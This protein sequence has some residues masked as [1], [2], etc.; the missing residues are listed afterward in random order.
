MESV[1]QRVQRRAGVNDSQGFIVEV[2]YELHVV[3]KQLEYIKVA[4][5]VFHCWAKV[6]LC[7]IFFFLF[8]FGGL[9]KGKHTVYLYYLYWTN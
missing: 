1:I 9:E 7:T 6:E 2:T 4:T 3:S 5:F 8:A